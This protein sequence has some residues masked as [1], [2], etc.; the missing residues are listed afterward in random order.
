MTWIQSQVKLL[1]SKI[2]KFDMTQLE[3]IINFG[4]SIVGQYANKMLSQGVLLPSS[5][6]FSWLNPQLIQKD[7]YFAISTDLKPI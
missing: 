6:T 5:Q 1:S 7:G 3:S 2:G 4:T